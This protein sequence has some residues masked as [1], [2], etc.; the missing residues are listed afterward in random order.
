M[1]AFLQE[2]LNQQRIDDIGKEINSIMGVER[3]RFVS[4]EEAAK[5]FKEEFGEDVSTVLD[6]NPLPPSFKIFL[7]EHYRTSQNASLISQR[8]KA[9]K[10]IDDVIYRREMLEF[11]ERQAS[12][13]DIIGL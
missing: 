3:V 6:F 7:N 9:I 12:V 2:P 13:L 1:E 5:V 8:V 11:I 10:G 4:K